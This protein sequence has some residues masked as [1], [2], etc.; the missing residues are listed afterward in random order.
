MVPLGGLWRPPGGLLGPK[1][2]NVRS[3]FPSGGPLGAVLGL[4]WAVLGASWPILERSWGPL[5]PSWSVGKPK[6]REAQKP[7]KNQWEINNV[8]FSGPSWKASRGLLGLSWRTLGLS[9]GHLGRL[10]ALVWRL[11]ALLGRPG[12]LLGPSWPVLGP[13]WPVL[14]PSWARKTHARTR[15]GAQGDR[16]K[17]KKI[18][19]IGVQAPKRLFRTEDCGSGD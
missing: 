8:A 12:G 19:Q 1:A 16:A 17:P 18:W 6:G 4:S 14:G 9:W 13:S 7:R 15:P 2:R 3:C 10:R 5:G 11:G